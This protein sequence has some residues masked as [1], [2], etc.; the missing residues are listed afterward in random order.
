MI[1]PRRGEI[2]GDALDES[3]DRAVVTPEIPAVS[4]QDTC[5]FLATLEP[6][7]VCL[8]CILELFDLPQDFLDRLP[9]PKVTAMIA[10]S[11]QFSTLD[12]V[13][14][15]LNASGRTFDAIPHVVREMSPYKALAQLQL[16][17]PDLYS[18]MI[19]SVTMLLSRKISSVVI[20]YSKWV[21]QSEHVVLDEAIEALATMTE[22]AINVM[23][24]KLQRI[25]EVEAELS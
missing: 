4:F 2:S 16:D 6:R 15:Y 14:T 17:N 18:N 9:L 19:S 24:R 3:R 10:P 11:Q 1:S 5:S 7:I 25:A 12:F 23:E 20:D 13:I 21:E 22:E 8:R